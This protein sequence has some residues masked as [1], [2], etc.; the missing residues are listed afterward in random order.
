MEGTASQ[1]LASLAA[2][3]RAGTPR[4]RIVGCD[5]AFAAA[6]VAGIAAAVPDGA[7]PL[8][9]VVPDETQA[10]ALARD[11][12]FYLPSAGG[13]DPGTP[14][15]VLH[16]PAVETSPY[17][18]LSP[19]RRAIMRRLA[20]L[21]R[22]SQGF[23]GQVLVCSAAAM[24]RRVIPRAELGKLA[25]IFLPEQE[26]RREELLDLLGRAGYGRAE[27]VEDPGTYAVR[28]GVIDLFVPLYRYPARIELF[29][30]LVESIRFFDPTTQRTMR[31]LAEL[32]VHPV[33]ETIRTTGADP[34]AR[35]L[36]AADAVD[37][38]SSKT[39]SLLEQ[40]ERGE[41]FFGAEAL[42]P[43]FHARMASLA[44]YLPQGARMVLLDRGAILEAATRELEDA[45]ERFE[46][47]R[48]EHRIALEPAE[49][50]LAQDELR[51]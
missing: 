9:V 34:R 38:P 21:F 35:I 40:V 4:V 51:D 45:R 26:I 5:R 31:P 33:R 1:A 7:R 6:A 36:H 14:P 19:D 12:T 50:F 17:A 41:D 24:C 15:R 47:R 25:D 11:L 46:M 13:D 16:L 39:R 29:G 49:H 2:H 22:L 32:Y 20:T 43:A 28:G 18:E 42:A 27:V 8:V 23:A 37:Y 48:A 10:L 3:A 30:D 44:E